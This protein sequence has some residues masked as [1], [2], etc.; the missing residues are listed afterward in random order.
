MKR[1]K[2]GDLTDDSASELEGGN[3]DFDPLDLTD[4]AKTLADIATVWKRRKS[5]EGQV[6]AS[7]ERKSKSQ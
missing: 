2:N 6:G 4:L 7:K 1:L 3:P 5:P